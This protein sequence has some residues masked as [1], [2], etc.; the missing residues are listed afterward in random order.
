MTISRK[1]CDWCVKE[2][3]SIQMSS[4]TLPLTTKTKGWISV[5]KLVQIQRLSLSQVWPVYILT[6]HVTQLL[7][8]A[9]YSLTGLALRC[10]L[11]KF[12]VSLHLFSQ[13]PFC[14][15]VRIRRKSFVSSSSG[16]V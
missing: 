2:T 6:G 16:L 8:M 10:Q 7:I 1:Q 14:L 12:V 13:W 3:V 5:K 9:T 4:F 15:V 11:V